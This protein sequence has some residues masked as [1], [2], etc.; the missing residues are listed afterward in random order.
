MTTEKTAVVK[1]ETAKAQPTISNGQAKEQKP[2]LSKLHVIGK[3]PD[4]VKQEEGVVK[5]LYSIQEKLEKLDELNE[6]VE[7]RDTIID[8][9]KNVSSFYISPA[10][11]AH[12]KFQDSKGNTFGIAHPSVIGEM[13]AM[14]SKKLTDELA[15]I[16]AKIDFQF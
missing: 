8:A 10:G 6:L 16:D 7:K 14:A 1:N 5:K 13:V 9:L 11:N 4:A 2:E 12:L 3:A 15:A